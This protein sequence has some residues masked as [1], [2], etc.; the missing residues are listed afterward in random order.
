MNQESAPCISIHDLS[1][2]YDTV[3]VLWDINLSIP[4]GKLVAIVGPNG[5]GKT[6]LL[7]TMLGLIKQVT[8]CVSFTGEHQESVEGEVAYV[9]QGGNIDWDFPLTVLDVVLMGTYRSLG[10]FKRP[11]KVQREFALSIL[12]EVGMREY[13]NR[14]IGE[15]SGGQQQRVFIARAL[16][17]QASIY[18]MDEPFKGVDAHTEKVIASLFRTLQLKG[19]T[20]LSVHH[21]LATVQEYFDWVVLLN[22]EVIAAGPVDEVFTQENVDKTYRRPT[23]I[24]RG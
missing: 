5:A 8:G 11:G 24:V 15:L 1:V 7:K 17:Q 10:W 20:I 6:T 22:R 9:P 3:P 18:A 16:A 19:K 23:T 21:D 12:E 2:A 4:A 13:S 14:Q